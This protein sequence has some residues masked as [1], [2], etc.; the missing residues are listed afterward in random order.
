MLKETYV[1][2]DQTTFKFI[3]NNDN[4]WINILDNINIHYMQGKLQL[5][6]NRDNII[7]HCM[8]YGEQKLLLE[9]P[10]QHLNSLCS[11]KLQLELNRDN[12]ITHCMLYGLEQ[13]RQHLNSLCSNKHLLEH[14]RQH[15]NLL[16]RKKHLLEQTRQ[17]LNSLCRKKHLLEHLRQH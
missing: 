8:L 2:T 15:L 6:L 3:A 13:P 17:H 1:G 4:K 12:I 11:N 9:Q 5:E 7:T 16:C 10:R 14:T